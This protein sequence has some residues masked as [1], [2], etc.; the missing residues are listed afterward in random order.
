MWN[1]FKFAFCIA[2]TL[3][4]V[5]TLAMMCVSIA[6]HM[7]AGESSSIPQWAVW[8]TAVLTGLAASSAVATSKGDWS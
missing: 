2:L 7:L 1:Y 5:A 8:V 4:G 3:M 6:P